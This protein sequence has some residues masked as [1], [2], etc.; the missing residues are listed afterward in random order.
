[1]KKKKKKGPLGVEFCLTPMNCSG[2]PRCRSKKKCRPLHIQLQL[3][4]PLTTKALL[5]RDRLFASIASGT[6][7][8]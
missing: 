7:C 1:M 2:F 4:L 6:Q 5:S 3:L 8:R